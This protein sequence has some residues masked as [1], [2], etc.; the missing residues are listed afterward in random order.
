MKTALAMIAAAVTTACGGGVD[1]SQTCSM[2]VSVNGG[3]Q[4][5][6]NCFAAGAFAPSTG[7]A[8][9]IAMN[10]VLPDLQAAQFGITLPSAP[11]VRTY[12]AVDV[13]TSIGQVQTKAGAL[14]VQSKS[15]GTGTFQ[16]VLTSVS[17]LSANGQT[18]YLLH[19]SATVTLVGQS[20][21]PGT[22]TLTATF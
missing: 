9:S 21:A 15:A 5:T 10:G 11:G 12:G 17:E 22:A 16:V 20:G 3:A 18:A 7:N 8:V 2:K 14:Y 6:V 19:G 4:E 13:N 1:L